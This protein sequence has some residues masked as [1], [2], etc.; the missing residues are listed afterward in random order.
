MHVEVQK[1]TIDNFQLRGSSSFSRNSIISAPPA[2]AIGR[3]RHSRRLANYFRHLTQKSNESWIHEDGTAVMGFL[4]G[5]NYSFLMASSIPSAKL[6]E[7]S[8]SPAGSSGPSLTATVLISP[9]TA[10]RAKRLQR[11]MIPT[12]GGPGWVISISRALVSVA[13][14]SATKLTK[15]PLIPWSSPQ[16]C[17]VC[18]RR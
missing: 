18:E 12:E 13:A 16:A 6:A 9:S 2:F 15:E 3:E 7:G 5:V 8:L 4:G 11:P 10:W 14:G 17:T 1:G